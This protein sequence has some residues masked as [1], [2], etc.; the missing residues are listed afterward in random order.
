MAR[1]LHN[2]KATIH[3]RCKSEGIP[4]SANINIRVR[5][6]YAL[7]TPAISIYINR[8]RVFFPWR[9]NIEK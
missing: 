4:R 3:V 5:A 1:Y 6:A 2:L 9:V 8:E 7:V